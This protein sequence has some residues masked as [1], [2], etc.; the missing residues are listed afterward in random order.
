MKTE[1]KTHENEVTLFGDLEVGETFLDRTIFGNDVVLM[2]IEP[3]YGLGDGRDFDG[4]ALSLD[5]GTVL[6][7]CNN[8]PITKIEAKVV[9]TR[10][11]EGD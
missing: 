6:G 1:Y 7:Y 3:A 11:Y 9:I 8:E 10:V 2:V 5:D 4:Y